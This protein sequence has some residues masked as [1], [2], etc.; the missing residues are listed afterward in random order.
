MTWIGVLLGSL[1]LFAGW[2]G[3][4]KAYVIE[5]RDQEH[6]RQERYAD[7]IAKELLKEDAKINTSASVKRVAIK[8]QTVRRKKE[9]NPESFLSRT[10]QEW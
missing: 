9:K 5:G 6:E 7:M 10:K 8:K 1:G 2:F 4:R 3:L